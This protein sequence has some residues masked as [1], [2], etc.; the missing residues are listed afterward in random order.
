MVF[1]RKP[2]PAKPSPPTVDQILEDLQI[3]EPDDPV[4]TLNPTLTRDIIE[5]DPESEV[6]KN[7]S[8]VIGY[9][10]KEKK[11]KQLQEKVNSGF[12]SLVSSQKEL[13]KVTG[14]VQSQLGNIKEARNKL[15]V[16]LPTDNSSQVC[17]T[18]TVVE[19]AEESE[20]DLC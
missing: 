20:D 13:E 8:D 11:L 6:N 4:Y 17:E 5:E 7:Y 3:A 19:K 18:L 9:V 10:S 1:G 2:A 16:E 14:E 12:E 15:V